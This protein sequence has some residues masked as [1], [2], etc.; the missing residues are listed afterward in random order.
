[1][2]KAT[3]FVDDHQKVAVYSD[4]VAL[5]LPLCVSVQYAYLFRCGQR[6]SIAPL[7]FS[8]CTVVT[9]NN[10]AGDKREYTGADVL[11]NCLLRQCM[12]QSKVP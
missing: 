7:E 5:D 11:D 3:F 4:R 6:D 8:L 10:S 12:A 9:E 1:M 2:K